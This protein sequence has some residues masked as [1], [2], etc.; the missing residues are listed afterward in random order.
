MVPGLIYGWVFFAV[1]VAIVLGLAWRWFQRTPEEAGWSL[2]E[3]ERSRIL[4]RLE[5][6]DARL[7]LVMGLALG[8]C[9]IAAALAIGLAPANG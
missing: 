3:L 5:A 4:S 2:A 6:F 7:P 8:A 1:V 9:A